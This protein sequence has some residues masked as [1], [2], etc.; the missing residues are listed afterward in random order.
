MLSFLAR[1]L[2]KPPP[3]LPTALWCVI[4]EYLDDMHRCE[5]LI[6][7]NFFPIIMFRYDQCLWTIICL[8]N[9][10]DIIL[11]YQYEVHDVQVN[12][13]F[14]KSTVFHEQ[15]LLTSSRIGLVSRHKVM[16]SKEVLYFL[17][18]ECLSP[19]HSTY[20]YDII[21]TINSSTEYINDDDVLLALY[22]Q[23]VSIV[24]DAGQPPLM[25]KV[26]KMLFS[27]TNY[28]QQGRVC[29]RNNLYYNLLQISVTKF[30]LINLNNETISII[31]NYLSYAKYNNNTLLLM[32]KSLNY[33]DHYNELV[34][35]ILHILNKSTTPSESLVIEI[36]ESL[37]ITNLEIYFVF[38]VRQKI[39]LYEVEWLIDTLIGSSDHVPNSSSW[40][41]IFRKCKTWS[42]IIAD[43]DAC[44]IYYIISRILNFEPFPINYLF[45]L[46]S[47]DDDDDEDDDYKF[48]YPIS[49]HTYFEYIQPAYEDFLLLHASNSNIGPV[50]LKLQLHPHY[51]IHFS[52]S[53]VTLLYLR[54]YH[55]LVE[56]VLLNDESI[57]LES[58]FIFNFLRVECCG[59]ND[60]KNVLYL[61]NLLLPESRTISDTL[62]MSKILSYAMR[63][64]YV[65]LLSIL[66]RHINY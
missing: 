61:I 37:N 7:F 19:I 8:R 9:R 16:I 54:G 50:L 22:F 66:Q 26:L 41:D 47:G 17:F 63:K 30:G 20:L 51:R 1:C 48:P 10:F 12:N 60:Q 39:W 35:L 59:V 49:E 29:T 2:P 65:N 6:Y 64:R 33:G 36:F 46:F 5:N 31:L 23:S 18:Y 13:I 38:L 58:E 56:I 40:D 21:K 15:L 57:P 27:A 32:L 25:T 52:S 62:Y 55:N 24:I 28:W 11:R 14:R 34:T 45:K 42:I 3:I 53:L 43:R 44:R 4:F